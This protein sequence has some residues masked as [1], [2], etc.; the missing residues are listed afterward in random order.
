MRKLPSPPPDAPILFLLALAQSKSLALA[1]SKS[2]VAGYTAH[3]DPGSKLLALAQS[4][5]SVAGYTAHHDPAPPTTMMTRRSTGSPD[6]QVR[7]Q[8]EG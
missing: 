3:H 4:K 7:I 6:L 8:E 2:S 5:S 1:Q